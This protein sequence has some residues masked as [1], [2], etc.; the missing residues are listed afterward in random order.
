[1]S[2]GGSAE[3]LLDISSLIESPDVPQRF[4]L[5]LA[6]DAASASSESLE[7]LSP[8]RVFGSA[9][10]RIDSVHIEAE[11]RGR[12]FI[13]CRRCLKPV[14]REIETTL[15]MDVPIGDQEQV[16]DLFPDIMAVAVAGI[17]PNVL[18]R[19]D[20][21]GLCPACGANLNDDPD[22]QCEETEDRPRRLGDLLR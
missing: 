8:L 2:Q 13:P 20:C 15:E 7:F 10:A 9:V 14:E 22:H 4:A 16:V 6:A 3:L 17:S 11:V 18:C 5:E 19:E 12:V 21:R 1:M